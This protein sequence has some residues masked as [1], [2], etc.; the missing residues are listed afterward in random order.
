MAI[1]NFAEFFGCDNFD[2]F[3]RKEQTEGYL[4]GTLIAKKIHEEIHEQHGERNRAFREAILTALRE[5][6]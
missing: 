2:I 1:Q 5:Q 3:E 6:L 4:A